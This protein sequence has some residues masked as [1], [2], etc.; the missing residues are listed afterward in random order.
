VNNYG[1]YV[2]VYAWWCTATP[3]NNAEHILEL[4]ENVQSHT[5]ESRQFGVN[6]TKVAPN[7][8]KAWTADYGN[9]EHVITHI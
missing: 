7:H 4:H 6:G 1:L 9:L 5:V 3:Q 2:D 8:Q